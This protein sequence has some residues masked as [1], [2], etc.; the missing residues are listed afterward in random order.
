M[1]KE[2]R[3]KSYRVPCALLI[4]LF[5]IF[6]SIILF[7]TGTNYLLLKLFCTFIVAV[8]ITGVLLY[9]LFDNLKIEE[10]FWTRYKWELLLVAA[11]IIIYFPIL[12]HS[13]LFYDDYWVFYSITPDQ[14]GQGIYYARPLNSLLFQLFRFVNVTNI[15][16]IKWFSVFALILFGLILMK[17]L[18]E[19]SKNKLISF[20]IT[21]V[22]CT[23]S[24]VIDSIGYGATFPFTLGILC[25][26]FSVISFKYAYDAL[27]LKRYLKTCLLAFVSCISLIGGFCA[28]QLST[29]IVFLFLAIILYFNN[30]R[31]KMLKPVFFY[32]ILF[33]ISAIIYLYSIRFF[34]FHYKIAVSTRGKIVNTFSEFVQKIHYFNST[35]LNQSINQLL[36]SIF[37]SS[38]YSGVGRIN[39]FVLA[40]I[41][42]VGTSLVIITLVI[43]TFSI[44]F[45][46]YKNRRIIDIILLL[47]FI[48]F[49]Y[50]TLF[51]LK[52]SSYVSY[53]VFPLVSIL[54][55]LFIMGLVNIL[56]IIQKFNNKIFVG[57]KFNINYLVLVLVVITAIQGNFYMS[58][59]WV[60]YNKSGYDYIKNS[61]RTQIDFN[62][63]IHIYG[64][65]YPGQGNVYSIFTAKTA[66][67]ELGCDSD[68]FKITTSDNQ[69]YISIIQAN[70]FKSIVSKLDEQSGK[71]LKT[72]YN[73]DSTYNRYIINLHDPSQDVLNKL[74]YC[75]ENSGYIPSNND[76]AII[77]NLGWVNSIK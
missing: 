58:R 22:V 59:F 1:H 56:D 13:Y 23:L 36:V 47:L 70:D 73:Y 34:S 31:K 35:I 11:I 68:S 54:T 74:H 16:Y 77:I 33:G 6:T 10:S 42:K 38:V 60:Y 14:L 66:L 17:W 61:I 9:L 5:T 71:W 64:V 21:A 40:K 51:V 46:W 29:P 19:F 41:P 62:H 63:W 2:S 39:V 55:F 18:Y 65:L 32:E 48:P 3:Y 7:G 45:C 52:E 67:K 49:S 24:S 75:F 15:F 76:N 30:T 26:S 12:T 69:Y 72:V 53:Y 4:C 27:K 50:Y 57:G 8:V 20:A 44:I 37:G 43:I 28:Y 25:S